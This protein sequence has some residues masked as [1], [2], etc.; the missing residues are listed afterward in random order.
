MAEQQKQ[1][2]E[3][4]KFREETERL[5][6]TASVAEQFNKFGLNQKWAKFFPGD[7]EPTDEAIRTFATEYE[8]GEVSAPAAPENKPFAPVKPGGSPSAAMVTYEDYQK[9]LKENP[10]EAFQMVADGRVE[11]LASTLD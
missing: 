5:T 9:I 11:G 8:L 4:L 3:L 7:T 1:A 10:N 2:E 6:R